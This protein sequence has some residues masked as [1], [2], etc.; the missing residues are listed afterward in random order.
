MK[1]QALENVV[2]KHITSIE[3]H[4]NRLPG[5]FDE[6]DIHDLRVSYKKARTFLRLLRVEKEDGHIRLPEKLKAVYHNC[7]KVRDMQLF[8]GALQRMAV[9][10]VLPLSITRWHQQL[11]TSKEQ[12][13]TAIEDIRFKKLREDLT[14]KLPRQLHNETITKFMHQKVAAIHIILLAAD[15]E[16]DLHSIRKQVKD[17]IFTIRIIEQDGGIPF[18]ISAW[19]NEE[20]LSNLAAALGDFNDRCITLSLL[21]SGYAN[22]DDEKEKCILQELYNKGLQQKEAQQQQLLQQVRALPLEH[23]F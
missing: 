1:R 23:T 15:N 2:I 20:E 14:K 16:E 18:P 12:T 21:Q 3:K 7:G 9:A 11:F 13:V 5:S 6:E 10:P 8:M 4:S 22:A 19:K 17:I